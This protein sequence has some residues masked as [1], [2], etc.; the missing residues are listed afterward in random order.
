MAEASTSTPKLRREAP[1]SPHLQVWRWHVTMA[2][3][4]LHRATGVALYVGAIGLVV[5]LAAGALGAASFGDI[6][7]ALNSIFGQIVL[8][9]VL[10]SLVYHFVNGLRHLVWDA[11]AGVNPRFANLTGWLS[12]IIA[13]IAPVVIFAL[14]AL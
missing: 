14:S 1:L 8:F 10:F 2:G 5:W 13:F 11:G 4:I 12:L 6:E 9:G 3:S 7:L